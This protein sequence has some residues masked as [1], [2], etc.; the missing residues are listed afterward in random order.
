M[1]VGI[2]KLHPE[3]IIP[4]YAH[5]GDAGMD[6]HSIEDIV[7]QPNK[8]TSVKTGL[9]VEIPEGYEIQ[10]RPRSGLAFKYGITIVNTPGTIDA[11]YRG[12]IVGIMINHG[13]QPYPIKKGE[14][15]GQLVLKK[16]EYMEF[17]VKEELSES[18]R[19][20]GGLGSTGY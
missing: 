3:A 6:L 20:E 15:I 7:L 5:K 19:G 10:V 18:S 8:V 4:K 9:S 14:R 2:K 11:G 1:K 16:V 12:E 17:E 13:E